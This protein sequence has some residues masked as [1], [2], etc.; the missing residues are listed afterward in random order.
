ML[1]H[2]ITLM[3]C[4][5]LSTDSSSAAIYHA[6]LRR[7]SM[8]YRS[9]YQAPGDV[10]PFHIGRRF[11][12]IYLLFTACHFTVKAY[13][14]AI[15]ALRSRPS[16]FLDSRRLF[17]QIFLCTPVADTACRRRDYC[18]HGRPSCRRYQCALETAAT[19]PPPRRL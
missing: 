11:R 8:P 10:P 14:V 5:D 3:P 1:K 7:W 16:P 12:F 2:A 9:H 13:L 18:R 6:E 19:A 17:A 15:S 4:H